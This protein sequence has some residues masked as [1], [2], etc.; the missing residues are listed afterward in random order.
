MTRKNGLVVK[1]VTV[2]A[3]L[4]EMLL[5]GPIQEAAPVAAPVPPRDRYPLRVFGADAPDKGW[6]YTGPDPFGDFIRYK[7]GDQAQLDHETDRQRYIKFFTQHGYILVF[8]ESPGLKV[9]S[10]VN[11]HIKQDG[12]KALETTM[13]LNPQTQVEVNGERNVLASEL[14]YGQP[15]RDG[16]AEPEPEPK[17]DDALADPTTRLVKAT[18]GGAYGEDGFFD[19]GAKVNMPTMRKLLADGHAFV[20][21]YPSGSFNVIIPERY[22]FKPEAI[23]AMESKMGLTRD[24]TVQ[25][26]IGEIKPDKGIVT[27]AAEAIYGE[28]R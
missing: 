21:K 20:I 1:G 27:T 26:F 13:G 10:K 19:G 17:D 22:H 14:F 4:V 5:D 28:K 18:F 23:K 15:N 8:K 24:S 9:Y 7:R 25:W 6:F 3:K 11:L 2:A 16:Q 12:I